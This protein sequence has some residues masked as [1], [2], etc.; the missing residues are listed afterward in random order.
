MSTIWMGALLL[1]CPSDPDPVTEPTVLPEDTGSALPK[2]DSGYTAPTTGDSGD[3][4]G[5]RFASGTRLVARSFGLKGSTHRVFSHFTDR[6]LGIPCSF[7]PATDGELRCLPQPDA[8]V[9]AQAFT[10]SECTDRVSVRA[11][12]DSDHLLIERPADRD[13][14]CDPILTEFEVRQAERIDPL[15]ALFLDDPDQGCRPRPEGPTAEVAVREGKVVAPETFVSARIEEVVSTQGIGV[16]RLVATDGAQLRTEVFTVRDGRCRPRY[17]DELGPRCVPERTALLGLGPGLDWWWQEP[18]CRDQPL[19]YTVEDECATDPLRF[20]LEFSTATD[21]PRLYRLNQRAVGSTVYDN[22]YGACVPLATSDTPWAFRQVANQATD[23]ALPKLSLEVIE[24]PQIRFR[25]FVDAFGLRVAPGFSEGR[26]G[27]S[28]DGPFE[29]SDG[30]CTAIA[31][32]D[33]T[34]R[35]LAETRTVFAGDQTARYFADNTCT[36]PL[37][38]ATDELPDQ[39]A[40]VSERVCGAERAGNAA[41]LI[42]TYDVLAPLPGNDLFVQEPGSTSC[43][44]TARAPST[45]YHRISGSRL[46]ELPMLTLE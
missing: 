36:D 18:S 35:C 30:P 41:V 46:V 17:L 5:P 11:C 27:R 21:A 32:A 7:R 6:K 31:A 33:G 14:A 42:D 2:T 45:T 3:A 16:R 22:R 28:G 4:L 24:E 25:Y 10:D 8:E 39:F 13:D 20:A 37:V 1:G 26:A 43:E 19:A 29:G 23:Q 9:T 34:P 44:S 38:P 40:I 15:P 12:G